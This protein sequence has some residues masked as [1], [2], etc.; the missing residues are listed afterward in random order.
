MGF[1]HLYP[2][3]VRPL[4]PRKRQVMSPSDAHLPKDRSSTDTDLC[5]FT[6][7]L[8]SL[9]LLSTLHF[10]HTLV[11]STSNQTVFNVA[12]QCKHRA[13]IASYIFSSNA[14]SFPP[15]APKSRSRRRRGVS[16]TPSKISP[17]YP[18]LA[19]R[20]RE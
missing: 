11:G 12:S 3:W 7:Q 13:I 2:S 17:L 14:S 9:N 19:L 8:L 4:R 6:L 15:L 1:S 18:P 5:P 10:H 16:E 20:S